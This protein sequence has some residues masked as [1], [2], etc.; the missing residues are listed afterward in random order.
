MWQLHH[1]FGD[2]RGEAI[3]EERKGV[4]HLAYRCLSYR[5]QHLLLLRSV[6]QGSGGPFFRAVQLPYFFP[7]HHLEGAEKN[8]DAD[9]SPP[10]V[11]SSASWHTPGFEQVAPKAARKERSGEQTLADLC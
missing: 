4:V 2:A 10:G 11:A 8:Q 3:A 6:C 5:S 9:S 7:S 1:L